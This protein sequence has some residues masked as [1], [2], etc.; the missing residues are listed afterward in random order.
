M[1]RTNT[2][3]FLYEWQQTTPSIESHA[4]LDENEKEYVQCTES[5][6]ICSFKTAK[7]VAKTKIVGNTNEQIC[8]ERAQSVSTFLLLIVS[9]YSLLLL[10]L[11]V[12]P[13]NKRIR[14]FSAPFNPTNG[15]QLILISHKYRF[16]WSIDSFFLLFEI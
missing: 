5:H 10:L 3:N 16:R 4:S 7:K 11:P 1:A 6:L 13:T 15:L 14:K 12:P 9:F 8:D 2:K